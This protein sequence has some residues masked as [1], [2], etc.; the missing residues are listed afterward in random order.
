MTVSPTLLERANHACELCASTDELSVY[1]VKS[2]EKS[3][4]DCAVV[5]CKNCLGQISGA[6]MSDSDH[7]RECLATSMWSEVP[8]VKVL[9][10]RILKLFSGETWAS[11]LMEIMYIEDDLKDWAEADTLDSGASD[12]LE[13]KPTCDSNGT[14]LNE[15]DTVTLIKDL[16]VKGAGF[17]AKRG[18]VVRN[19]RLT[20]NPEHIEGKVGGQQIVLVSAFLKKA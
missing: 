15:G 17:T 3:D 13:R 9:A 14:E 5:L 6:A 12:G 11:G 1:H 2:A 20:D 4:E 16:Q 18:T 19:I 8:A 10:W 7:W